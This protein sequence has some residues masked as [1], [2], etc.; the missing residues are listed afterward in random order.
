MT[1]R[2]PPHQKT[3][4]RSAGSNIDGGILEKQGS[5]QGR[6]PHPALFMP[7]L[8]CGVQGRV[9]SGIR[10]S[11]LHVPRGGG[12][13]LLWSVMQF[14][15]TGRFTSRF[16]VTST[17]GLSPAAKAP[18][19]GQGLRARC[20]VLPDAGCEFQHDSDTRSGNS[21]GRKCCIVM[22]APACTRGCRE[23][24]ENCSAAP[25]FC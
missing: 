21:R 20:G 16:T 11:G 2:C 24:E 23:C 1:A 4:P 10:V 22:C 17:P 6:M 7:G 12:Q 9:L 8:V 19:G 15:V 5:K 25:R 14:R 3:A 18:A 13:E